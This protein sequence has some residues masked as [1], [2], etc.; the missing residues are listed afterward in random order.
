MYLIAEALV[1]WV[2]PVLSFTSD[3][4]W[5]AMPGKRGETVFTETWYDGLFELS[6]SESVSREDWSNLLKVR[7]AVSKELESLRVSGDIG[8]ALDAS[9]SLYAD[10][11]LMA[12][13]EK[14]QSELRFMLITSEAGVAALSSAPDSAKTLDVEGGKLAIVAASAD[15]EKCVRCWHYRTDVGNSAE[16]SELCQR[17]VDNVSGSG[18]KRALA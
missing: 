10:G 5:Q 14:L 6:D 17:C 11:D 7:A 4:I 8:G 2:S 18:E 12:S 3:E 1:R 13:L 16:H 9:V 15:G